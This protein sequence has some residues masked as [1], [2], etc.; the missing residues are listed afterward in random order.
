MKFL[1]TRALSARKLIKESN[2]VYATDKL[3]KEIDYSYNDD[4]TLLTETSSD[5][6]DN[7][8]TIKK[9]EYD[10]HGSVRK[11]GSVY[12]DGYTSAITYTYEK[13]LKK[14]E[15]KEENTSIYRQVFHYTNSMLD[16]VK[17]YSIQPDMSPWLMSTHLYTYKNGLFN[18]SNNESNYKHGKWA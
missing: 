18:K 17:N 13:E 5:K 8:T 16:S 4:G 10:A 9:H 7:Y 3:I 15:D 6:R 14:V 11:L 2:Y 1:E 12:P